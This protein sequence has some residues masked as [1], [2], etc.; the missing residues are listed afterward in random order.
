MWSTNSEWKEAFNTVA[1][2][3]KT[4]INITVQKS[5][6]EY[7]FFFNLHYS[8]NVVLNLRTK[9]Y[10]RTKLGSIVQ[11]SFSSTKLSSGTKIFSSTKLSSRTKIFS[12]TNL[13]S[14]VFPQFKVLAGF[15]DVLPL[16]THWSSWRHHV[17][18]VAR[19]S[20]GFVWLAHSV[21]QS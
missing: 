13:V 8:N 2:K 3:G 12:S 9:N 5:I 7:Q 4:N 20:L 19:L 15:K 6:S 18:V 16:T 21:K 14:N 1:H 10:S 17:K 11:N